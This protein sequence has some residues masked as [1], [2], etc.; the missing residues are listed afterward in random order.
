M[1]YTLDMNCSKKEYDQQRYQ[2]QKERLLAQHRQW[3][4]NNPN[5]YKNHRKHTNELQNK[6]RK[7]SL[8]Y[9]RGIYANMNQRCNNPNCPRYNDYGGRGIKLKFTSDEF[10][11]YIINILR[12]EPRN[13]TIDRI[14][15]DGHYEKGNIR[16]VTSKENNRNKNRSCNVK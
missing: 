9:L 7:T 1:E 11:N 5:Y 16:F 10:V 13:L 8:G 12:I 3:R 15:N 6:R 4:K 2:R 14:D